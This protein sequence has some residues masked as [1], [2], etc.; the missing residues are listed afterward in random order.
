MK[1]IEITIPNWNDKS[2]G[3]NKIGALQWARNKYGEFKVATHS[4]DGSWSKHIDVLECWEKEWWW[5][6]DTANNR[7]TFAS[8]IVLDFDPH[9]NAT[10]EEI[11]QEAKNIATKLKELGFYFNV[12][13]TGSRGFH[14]HLIFPELMLLSPNQRKI[15]KEKLIRY[16]G[17]ELL[18]ASEGTMIAL[19]HELHWKT[20]QMKLEVD[21][22]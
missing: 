3:L 7:T 18:K 13:F 6:L 12:Y 8:E 5:R 9:K 10:R 19:E 15:L 2:H 14:F 20:G 21:L 17:C 22:E 11:N 16:S 1:E 4:P